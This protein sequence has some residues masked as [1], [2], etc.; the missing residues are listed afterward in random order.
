MTE[1]AVRE[2]VLSWALERSSNP[3]AVK[4]RFPKLS[5]WLQGESRPTL[6]QLEAFA[7]ATS[8]PLGYLFLSEPPQEQLP[9]P[10][11]RTLGDEPLRQASPNLLEM[12][13]TMEQRQAWMREYLMEQGYEPLSFV[14]SA[15]VTDDPEGIA[16]HIRDTLN[17]SHGWATEHSTWSGALENL[18]DKIEE[19]SI[20]VVLNSIVGNNTH[21]KLDPTEFRGFVLVDEY[22]PLVFVNRADSKAAQMFTLAH[23]LAHIWLGSSA[24]FDLRELQPAKNE[25]ERACNRVAAEFL[26]STVELRQIWPSI[27]QDP[28]RFQMIAR[29]FKVSELVAAR[30]ALDLQLITKD[31]FL[32]FYRA[33]QELE[34]RTVSDRDGGNFYATQNLRLGRR[35]AETVVRAVKEGKLLYRDAYR[36]TGLYGRT[37]E[38]YTRF[39]LG[40]RL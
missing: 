40:E 24:A 39:L 23:E 18:R 17:L 8:T 7:K 20:L 9:I 27:R 28:N 15:Q 25:T 11:F 30:R 29:Q 1:V 31:E 38:Q 21:R 26:V 3:E 36:L 35:F 16:H 14:S 32:N 34:H 4:L 37:F 2:S 19:A 33:Y 10:Y 6:R 5:E 22:A 13:Q 12:V